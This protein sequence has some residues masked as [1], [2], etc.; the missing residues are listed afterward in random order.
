[1]REARFLALGFGN[2]RFR[3]GLA[4]EERSDLRAALFD[5]L[6]ALPGQAWL[7]GTDREL[8]EAFGERAQMLEVRDGRAQAA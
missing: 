6:L 5:E 2:L 3:L 7:T 1:M 4:F 8:F